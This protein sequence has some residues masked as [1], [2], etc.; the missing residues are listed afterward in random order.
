MLVFKLKLLLFQFSNSFKLLSP[1]SLLQISLQIITTIDRFEVSSLTFFYL[2]ENLSILNWFWATSNSFYFPE[3]HTHQVRFLNS[4]S[5]FFFLSI[6]F[7]GGKYFNF[8]LILHFSLRFLSLFGHVLLIVFSRL[9]EYFL[10]YCFTG[11]HKMLLKD[12]SFIMT[13]HWCVGFEVST[14]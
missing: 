1:T 9:I 11:L 7:L 4:N 3:D 2:E 10:V 6:F 5:D 8:K 12:V 14:T 13:L